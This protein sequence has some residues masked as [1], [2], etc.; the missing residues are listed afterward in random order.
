MRKHQ[1]HSKS[2]TGNYRTKNVPNINF[3]TVQTT[4]ADIMPIVSTRQLP[5]ESCHLITF[6]VHRVGK[7]ANI[8]GKN[9]SV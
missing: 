8:N 5:P 7:T 4:F 9:L 2:A 3:S 1:I 6:V